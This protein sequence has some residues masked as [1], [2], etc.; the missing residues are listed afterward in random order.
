MNT[1]IVHAW[2]SNDVIT[3]TAD[4]P[5]TEAA[6]LM[7][8]YNIRRLP[9]VQADGQVAGIVT[10][11]DIRQAAASDATSLNIWELPELLAKVQVKRVMSA[12]PI[13]VQAG[14]S[15]AIAAKLMLD[16]KV[17]GLPVIDPVT[18]HLQG[19]ITESDIFRLV[20]K[21]WGQVQTLVPG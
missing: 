10:I 12:H 1:E 18:N 16:H 5:L 9:V 13:T 19:I 17:G 20:V 14:D 3:V 21:L 6:N 15:V 11:G 2:M 8:K 7:K 4:S